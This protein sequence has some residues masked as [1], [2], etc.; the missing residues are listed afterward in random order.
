MF[1]NENQYFHFS[2][3]FVTDRHELI[4]GFISRLINNRIMVRCTAKICS[5][6]FVRISQ[7]FLNYWTQPTETQPTIIPPGRCFFDY[8]WGEMLHNEYFSIMHKHLYNACE[9]TA[10]NALN[11]FNVEINSSLLC[12]SKPLKNN[13]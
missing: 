6:Q 8:L 12:I 5:W 9:C 1:F 7:H 13:Y 2:Y 4:D 10:L 3:C 11:K